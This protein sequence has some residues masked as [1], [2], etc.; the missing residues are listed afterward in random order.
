MLK[1][2]KENIIEN[3]VAYLSLF[4]L[5][6]V[7]TGMFFI[8][9]YAVDTYYLEA[10]GYRNNAINPYLK[11]GR[12][13][14]TVFLG[15]MGL[16]NISFSTMKIISWLVAVLSLYTSMILVYNTIDRFIKKRTI[17]KSLLSFSLIF[18]IFVSEYFMFPEYTGIMCLGILMS[19]ITTY[20]L[21]GYFDNKSKINLVFAYTSA[22]LAAFCYQGC[23][24]LLVLLPIGFTLKYSKNIKD[25]IV[26]N[27]LIAIGYAI[28]SFTTLIVSKLFGS[29]RTSGGLNIMESLNNIGNSFKNL[30]KTTYN[31]LPDYLFIIL[32]VIVIVVTLFALVKNKETISKYLFLGYLLLAVIIVTLVPHFLVDTNSIWLVPRSNIGLGLLV[33]MPIMCYFF[34][35]KENEYITNIF[36]G[37]LIILF[38]FQFIGM[39]KWLADQHKTNALDYYEGLILKEEVLNY[40]KKHNQIEKIVIYTSPNPVYEYPNIKAS[41]D[42][43]LRT[44]SAN[45]SAKAIIDY[46][47][48]RKLSDGQK[49]DKIYKECQEKLAMS[50][51]KNHL[52][53]K[54]KTMYVC[55]Y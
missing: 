26:N 2:L 29:S 47:L 53:F 40:E 37:I 25:F 1:K 46:I 51:N 54:D 6:L 36:I 18:N 27:I 21:I 31:I 8:N 5:L 52:I 10:Y 45:W 35:I 11:D 14:M 13:L 7:F 44:F 9:R 12:L 23:L 48:N 49:D 20:F 34:Y 41:G 33:V 50:K 38:T 39:T 28:P 4:L 32:V 17:L 55:T 42:V 15:F 19:A 16:F 3:K 30:M 24:S 22:L 43:N